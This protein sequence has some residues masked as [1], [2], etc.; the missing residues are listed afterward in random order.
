[1]QWGTVSSLPHYASPENYKDLGMP[2]LKLGK[3]FYYLTKSIFFVLVL[4]QKAV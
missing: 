1:M 2:K 3:L 4:R